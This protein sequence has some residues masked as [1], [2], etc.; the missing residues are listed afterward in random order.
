VFRRA[1]ARRKGTSLTLESPP[2]NSVLFKVKNLGWIIVLP[3]DRTSPDAPTP[4]DQALAS[5]GVARKTMSSP[6]ILNGT[7][8]GTDHLKVRKFTRQRK[9]KER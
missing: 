4:S 7:R 2:E 1:G 6:L 3:F 5:C 8:R 9:G